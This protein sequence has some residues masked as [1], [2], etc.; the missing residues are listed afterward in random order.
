MY[1]WYMEKSKNA[2]SYEAQK[3]R[4]LKR[5][6][7][8]IQERGGSCEICGYN[9]NMAALEFHHQ[10]PNEKE[11]GIDM[12][13]FANTKLETLKLE[14]DKC[15][16]LCSNCHREIHN[17]ELML[18]NIPNLIKKVERTTFNN[19][20]GQ[21]CPV[22]GKRFP[23][24]K[25]KIYCSSTCRKE[26]KGY[27]SFEEVQKQ[28]KLLNSWEKVAQHFGLTRKIIQGIRSN[29]LKEDVIHE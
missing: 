25:G 10:D 20:T 1:L 8:I 14:L 22:C 3:E 15:T 5:K 26:D 21:I 19:P 18:I 16:L 11:F 23:K 6:Y 17:Q 9:K 12:R 13:T 4:G 28:Y 2:N 24:S 27:P 29:S 7:E